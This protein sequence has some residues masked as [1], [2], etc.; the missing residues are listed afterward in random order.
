MTVERSFPETAELANRIE[1]LRSLNAENWRIEKEPHDYED[2]TKHFNHVRYTSKHFGED[3]TVEVASYVSPELGE[4]LCL[5]NNNLDVIIGALRAPAQ[6]S[7]PDRE[8]MARAIAG[9]IHCDEECQHNP[10]G[11][12]CSLD[13]A[14]AIIAALSSTPCESAQSAPEPTADQL[15]QF[16]NGAGT[17]MSRK[18]AFEFG[19][20]QALAALSSTPSAT[21]AQSVPMREAL[22]LAVNIIMISEPGDSRA[23][24][25]EAVALAAVL[26]G[27]TS[28]PV[29]EVIRNALSARSSTDGGGK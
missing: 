27:D 23:V 24:S 19:W 25:N 17:L 21:P 4:L 20:K 22:E 26:A 16:E 28:G 11:C 12:D 13:A 1:E 3:V 6:S 2:G 14:D 29:M 18:E 5:L 9:C 15:A 7:L 8:K 10:G